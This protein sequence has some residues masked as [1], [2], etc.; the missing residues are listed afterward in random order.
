MCE[1]SGHDAFESLARLLVGEKQGDWCGSEPAFDRLR[2]ALGETEPIASPLDLSV[3]LRQALRYEFARRGYEVSPH[4]LV[5]NERLLSFQDW[6]LVGLSATKEAGGLRIVATAWRPEWLKDSPV[7]GVD[8]EAS[9]ERTKRV[10]GAE[11][12][13]GDL[14]LALIGRKSYRSSG[15]RAAVRA[16]LSTPPAATL[17]VA[18]PTGEGKSMIFQLIQAVGFV[19][20]DSSASQGVTLVIVPTVA[21][22]V[23]HE[24]EAVNVC[25]LPKP[26]AFQGGAE[27]ANALIA[28]RISLGIQGLCFASPEAA[29]SRLRP[30][31]R[32]AAQAGLLRALVVDEAHLVDQWGTGFRT[33]FQGLSGLRRELIALAPKQKE[34]RTIL[35]SATLTDSSLETLRAL[36]A[37]EGGFESCA[38]VRLRPEPDY[39]VA[40]PNDSQREGRVLE[41]LHH[42]PRPAVLYVTE[43]AEAEMWRK[44]LY[45]AG[46]RRLAMLHGSTNRDTREKVVRQWRDGALDVVVGTSAFGLGIDFAHARSVVHACI[47]ETLDRFYQEVGRGGRDGKSSLSLIVPTNSDMMTAKGINQ[48]QIMTVEWG[49]ERWKALFSGKRSLGA[50]QFAVRVDGSPGANERDIDMKGDQ[51]TDWNLRT[52][53]LMARAGIIRLHGAPHPAITDNGDWFALEISDDA[54]LQKK[55]W[56]NKIEPVR[57]QS[58]MA[59]ARNLDLMQRYLNDEECPANILESLYG[60]GRISKACSRCSICRVDPLARQPSG[61]VAELKGPW[62]LPLDPL[63][64]RLL[65]SDGR[66][67]VTYQRERVGIP[68]SRRLGVSISRLQRIALAKLIL[69]GTPPF[70]MDRVLRAAETKPIFVS[71]LSSLAHSRLPDGPEFVIFGMDEE[72]LQ[73]SIDPYEGRSRILLVPE[74]QSTPHGR[75]LRDVFG[76]RVL[77]LDEFNERV[78]L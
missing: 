71:R 57:L 43:V 23:N 14:F 50:G 72:I 40:K 12:C 5:T 16:A 56:E 77:T 24:S 48:Q 60:K 7:Q 68:E 2:V 20:D 36:F 73:S 39:W 9:S 53:S 61:S 27:A 44:E 34:L 1:L 58:H 21:L 6:N 35:L 32:S 47:P 64:G 51:N 52:L 15:Q 41:A 26:L 76:G 31:L 22:A 30:A 28:E 74:N 25:K 69:I 10:F 78:A 70:K 33:E 3:L 42:I 46:F 13:E 8:D 11:G 67:L 19:G 17:V 37:G 49:F 65:G 29:C 4:V 75:K 66:L 55:H 59:S 63:L 18:L 38:A 54:H 45:D 62:R